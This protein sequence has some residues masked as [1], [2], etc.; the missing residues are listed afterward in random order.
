M[1]H[2][3][4]LE[5]SCKFIASNRSPWYHGEENQQAEAKSTLKSSELSHYSGDTKVARSRVVFIILMLSAKPLIKSS[6][7]NN[8]CHLLPHVICMEYS[9][10]LQYHPGFVLDILSVR[11]SAPC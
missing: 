4:I 2:E 9:N 8:F 7:I 10:V 1:L 11:H 6:L 3:F 5:I